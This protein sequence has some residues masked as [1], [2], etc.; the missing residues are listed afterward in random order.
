MKHLKDSFAFSAFSILFLSLCISCAVISGDPDDTEEPSS[1]SLGQNAYV[2]LKISD[3]SSGARTINPSAP[4]TSDLKNIILAGK[5]NGSSSNTTIAQAV[6][7]SEL[8]SK[9]AIEKGTWESFTLEATIGDTKYSA[10]TTGFT[11][12]RGQNKTLTFSL[13]E[14]T[15]VKGHGGIDFTLNLP[16]TTVKSAKIRLL[17]GTGSNASPML[18]E[19]TLVTGNIISFKKNKDNASEYIEAGTYRLTIT[20]FADG[21]SAQS[22]ELNVY[23]AIVNIAGGCTSTGSD[24]ITNLHEIYTIQYLEYSEE[25]GDYITCTSSAAS[26]LPESYT[27]KSTEIT[28]PAPLRTGSVF[29]GWYKDEHFTDS[30]KLSEITSGSTGNLKLYAKWISMTVYASSTGNDSYTGTNSKN[31]VKT[32]QKAV[33]IIDALC[34]STTLTLPNK[35]LTIVVSGILEGNTT[36]SG[37]EAS[38]LTI[39]GK[40]GAG[41]DKLDGKN[42][43]KVLDFDVNIPVVIKDLTVQNGKSTTSGAGISMDGTGTLTLTDCVVTDNECDFLG[44]A[45]DNGGGGGIYIGTNSTVVLNGSTS[46]I[47]NKTPQANGKGGGILNTGILYIGY[48]RNSSGTYIADS[49]FTGGIVS[50]TSV[51]GG[52]IYN[53]GTKIYMAGGQISQNVATQ[54]GGAIRLGGN[55]DEFKITGCEIS[56]N[57]AVRYGGAFYIGELSSAVIAAGSISKNK[58]LMGGAVYLKGT[59][60]L[61]GSASI[62]AETDGSND[63]YLLAGT[64]I[65][66]AGELIAEE[67]VATI[68]PSLASAETDYTIGR[69]VLAGTANLLQSEHNKFAVTRAGTSGA[70]WQID[71]EGKLKA[72]RTVYVSQTGNDSNSG[73]SKTEAVAT[74]SKAVDVINAQANSLIDWTVK[75]SGNVKGTTSI[76]STLKAKSLLIEG[77]DSTNDILDGQ[78][79]TAGAILSI[80]TA[81]PVT[82]LNL[83]ITKGNSGGIYINGN[84]SVL[85][86]GDGAKI[87]G[88]S[89]SSGAGI[90]VAAANLFM[91]G[92][93]TIENNTCTQ[94]G[95]GIYTTGKANIYLGYSDINTKETLTGGIIN[96]RATG[97]PANGA[98]IYNGSYT[99]E[100]IIDSG[101]I[102]D[103]SASGKGSGIY[104]TDTLT[105]TGGIISQNNDI[106]LETG[107]TINIPSSI[108]SSEETI[109]VITPKTYSYGTK[110]LSGSAASTEYKKFALTPKS[111]E[112]WWIGK[113]GTLVTNS[114]PASGSSNGTIEITTP[115]TSAV[116][117]VIDGSSA[118]NSAP[119][120]IISSGEDASYYVTIK[121]VRRNAGTYE[122]A[123]LLENNTPGTT[124]TVYLTVNGNC[125][126]NAGNHGGIKASGVSGAIINVIFLTD[127]TAT[128]QFG[129]TYTGI[130]D[131]QVENV[132]A[133]FSFAESCT[134]T[135]ARTDT[136]NH[137]TAETF[138]AAA[139]TCTN[140]CE[141]TITR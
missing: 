36:I 89:S 5:K 108:T 114:I 138:F 25:S 58:G 26:I 74:L 126:L 100:I 59:L 27:R 86:L 2:T 133:T 43:D 82:I 106:Y 3:I 1:Q 9:I 91:Y 120:D 76:D 110:V 136:V 18:E 12:N 10:E 62:P 102:S 48:K 60:N 124:L 46:V 41:T 128:L 88:N 54:D 66:V 107:Q 93:A 90:W 33:D 4:K 118:G 29:A 47:N 115:N 40:T 131:L 78:N 99:G 140:G 84:S 135:N 83:T 103:N 30:K 109:A 121:D 96:N 19:T 111:G 50:N 71:E 61:S 32:L 24:T 122:S 81:S 13:K 37:T 97:T 117:Y 139:A 104:N 98:G 67:P 7:W 129:A 87:S 123:L 113:D 28:L 57:T 42:T 34:T 85:K 72:L 64:K 95:A 8:P 11:I 63:V 16:G 101:L 77:E 45:N 70:N 80:T 75:V 55:S 65:T 73:L 112:N 49:S 105:I 6:S 21:V 20:L 137:T 17:Q 22:L 79:T 125:L 92:T 51:Y 53:S 35:D 56:Q 39:K 94:M 31:A 134:V 23:K 68:T 141:F 15:A 116:P 52:G 69:Q 44:G 119:I 132:T 127:S 130:T 38:S 14:S